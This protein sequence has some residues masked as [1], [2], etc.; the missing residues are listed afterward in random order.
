MLVTEKN[1]ADRPVRDE[2]LTEM[3]S[4][5]LKNLDNAE[6]NVAS[7]A[8]HATMSQPVLYRKIKALTGLSV[9]DFIKSIRLRRAAELLCDPERTVYEVAYMVGFSDRKYFSREFKKIYE[10][11]PSA[12]AQHQRSESDEEPR[13]HEI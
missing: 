5:I 1:P 11:T 9:N 2:F 12:Y 6:F 4:H 13:P 10:M 7:L 8:K 3:S